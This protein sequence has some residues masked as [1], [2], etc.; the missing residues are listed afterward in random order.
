MLRLYIEYLFKCATGGAYFKT[1]WGAKVGG[2]SGFGEFVNARAAISESEFAWLQKFLQ[3]TDEHSTLIDVGANLGLFSLLFCKYSSSQNIF[4]FEPAP[5]TY[6]SLCF[7]LTQNSC[8][9]VVSENLALSDAEKIAQFDFS[10]RARALAHLVKSGTDGGIDVRCTTLDRYADIKKLQ[11]ISLLKVDVEGWEYAVFS[12]A[13]KLLEQRRIDTI[14]FEFCPRWEKAVGFS[15]GDAIGLLE[16]YGFQISQLE[17]NGQLAPFHL[18]SDSLPYS[19]NL[20][21]QIS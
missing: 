20:V 19:T 11:R 4:C 17:E 21:A 12:G 18:K 15:V 6:A 16:K 3:S 9:R 13:R 8:H 2:L 1:A 10:T 5:S 7:N 14:Y